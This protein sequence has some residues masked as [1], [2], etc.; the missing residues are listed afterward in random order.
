MQVKALIYY[1]DPAHRKATTR[2]HLD[3]HIAVE[4]YC[5]FG[6]LLLGTEAF[7]KCTRGDIERAGNY[8]VKILKVSCSPAAV[9]VGLFLVDPALFTR[10]G[11]LS[12][13]PHVRHRTLLLGRSSF[14]RVWGGGKVSW[15]RFTVN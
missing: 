14:S 7:P 10:P 8:L 1:F 4:R 15:I 12:R 9:P 11:R 6:R 5:A 13:G 3:K 2:T